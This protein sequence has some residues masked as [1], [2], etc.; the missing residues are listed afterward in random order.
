MWFT[1]W[2][3]STSCALGDDDELVVLGDLVALEGQAVE[4]LEAGVAPARLAAG[5]QVALLGDDVPVARLT[6]APVDA[7]GTADLDPCELLALA[8]ADEQLERVLRGAAVQVVQLAVTV[9]VQQLGLSCHRGT[10]LAHIVSS[11]EW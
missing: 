11:G 10:R 8:L 3:P 5:T 7:L 1:E 4:G 6:G 9:A 2:R